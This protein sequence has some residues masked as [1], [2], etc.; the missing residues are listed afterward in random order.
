MR[1]RLRIAQ[2]VAIASMVAENRCVD[3][4]T[5]PFRGETFPTYTKPKRKRHAA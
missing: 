3:G 1:R 2:L 4:G 5:Q